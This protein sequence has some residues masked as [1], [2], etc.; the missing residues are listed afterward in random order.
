MAA[1][2]AVAAVVAAVGLR[3]GVQ[4]ELVADGASASD[5]RDLAPSDPPG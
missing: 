3:R 2:M 1:V 4:E 5:S